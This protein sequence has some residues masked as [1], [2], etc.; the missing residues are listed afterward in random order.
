[1]QDALG[2]KDL[3]VAVPPPTIEEPAEERKPSRPASP[4]HRSCTHKHC[5]RLKSAMCLQEVR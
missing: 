2:I 3:K 1:L 5:E 4:A